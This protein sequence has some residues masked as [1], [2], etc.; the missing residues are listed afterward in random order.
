MTGSVDVRCSP[1][2]KWYAWGGAISDPRIAPQ[3]R[4]HYLAYLAVLHPGTLPIVKRLVR[5]PLDRLYRWIH[6][7]GYLRNFA[8]LH[9]ISAVRALYH[10]WREYR[11][12]YADAADP[13]SVRGAAAGLSSASRG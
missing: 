3:V 8:R 11:F 12:T 10:A 6:M 9:R 4:L 5:L 1:V 2:L 13:R 7:L